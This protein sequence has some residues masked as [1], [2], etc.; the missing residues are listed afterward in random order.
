MPADT[1]LFDWSASV[2]SC[3]ESGGEVT[4]SLGDLAV[5]AGA[6]IVLVV[7]VDAAAAGNLVNNATAGSD[8]FDGNSANNQPSVS[9][10]VTADADL[11]LVKGIG[12]RTVEI[13]RDNIRVGAATKK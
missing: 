7:D 2:G 13:N 12:E 9:T 4:C 5:D 6:Q 8:A 11:S 1:T 3:S 10:P